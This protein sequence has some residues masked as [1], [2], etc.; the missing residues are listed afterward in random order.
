MRNP[1]LPWCGWLVASTRYENAANTS[2]SVFQCDRPRRNQRDIPD[3]A[4][5]LHGCIQGSRSQGLGSVEM[6]IIGGATFREGHQGVVQEGRTISHFLVKV[7]MN[8]SR[9]SPSQ[10]LS[11]G[12]LRLLALSTLKNDPRLRGVLC[13]EEPENG[14]LPHI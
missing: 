9:I 8:D 3:C 12:T 11:D 13:L 7:R 10:V 14:F 4:T 1:P 6:H 2:A 5:R